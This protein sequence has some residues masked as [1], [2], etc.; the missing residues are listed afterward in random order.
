[1]K[2]DGGKTVS[3]KQINLF[4]ETGGEAEKSEEG[5]VPTSLLKKVEKIII[6]KKKFTSK[7]ELK[8]ILL[9]KVIKFYKKNKRNHKEQS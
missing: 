5:A 3:D 2:I 6:K 7:Q 9:K 8:D 1:M 4:D